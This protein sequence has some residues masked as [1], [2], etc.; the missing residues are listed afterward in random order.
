[1]N[2]VAVIGRLRRLDP[3]IVFALTNFQASADG[4]TR[5]TCSNSTVTACLKLKPS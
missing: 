3:F 1:M 2:S 4:S 5:L